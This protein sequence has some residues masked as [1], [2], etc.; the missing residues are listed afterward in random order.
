MNL[1]DRDIM[2]RARQEGI[3]LGL[4]QGISQGTRQKAVDAARNA[5]K[6]NLSVEQVSQITNLSLEEI[7]EL[8]QA[9]SE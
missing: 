2:E 9:N 4:Q 8:A 3:E 5:L 6:M 1:H 7:R